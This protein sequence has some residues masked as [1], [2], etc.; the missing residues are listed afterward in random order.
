M[1][2][3]VGPFA[4]ETF[5][6]FTFSHGQVVGDETFIGVDAGELVTDGAVVVGVGVHDFLCRWAMTWSIL[7]LSWGDANSSGTA[8]PLPEHSVYN[9]LA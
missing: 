7:C 6:T 3:L 2:L 5:V 9:G 1:S 8:C 4:N